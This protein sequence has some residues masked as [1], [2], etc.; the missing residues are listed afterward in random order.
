MK[1]MYNFIFIDF[2]SLNRPHKKAKKC[3][4]ECPINN[5]PRHTSYER[6]STTSMKDWL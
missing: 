5:L 2:V 6:G 1:S 4:C 3:L